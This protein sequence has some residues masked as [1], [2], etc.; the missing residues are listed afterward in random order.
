MDC[1][2]WE[3]GGPPSKARPPLAGE[4]WKVGPADLHM[5]VAGGWLW[6]LSSS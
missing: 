4:P 1:G 3:D 2:G 6:V 5:W